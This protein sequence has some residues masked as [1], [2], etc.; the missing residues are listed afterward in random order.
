VNPQGI[1]DLSVATAEMRINPV[2]PRVGQTAAFA[3]LVRNLGTANVQGAVVMFNLLVN[4]AQAGASQPMAF[5]VAGHGTFQ[6]NWSVLIPPG[7]QY[8]VVVT[9]NAR[10]DV[11]LANNRAVLAFT[12]AAR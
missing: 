7:K 2:T 8:Q 4:G 6:A 1:V 5:N 11:N 12:S 3:A 9:V 10:G